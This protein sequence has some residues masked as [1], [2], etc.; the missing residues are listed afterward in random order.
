MNQLRILLS[1][2]LTEIN[3]TVHRQWAIRAQTQ[4]YRHV[5]SSDVV[6]ALIIDGRFAAS[7]GRHA[8]DSAA[9]AELRTDT[10]VLV[11]ILTGTLGQRDKAPHSTAPWRYQLLRDSLEKLTSVVQCRPSITLPLL[12]TVW[13]TYIRTSLSALARVIDPRISPDRQELWSGTTSILPYKQP[14]PGR[15]LSMLHARA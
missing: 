8:T 14:R 6:T 13:S 9:E 7:Q 11:C 4:C 12:A 1:L 5:E 3:F 15:V 10:A 2:P